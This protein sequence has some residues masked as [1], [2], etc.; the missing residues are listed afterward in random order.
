MVSSLGSDP[1]RNSYIVPNYVFDGFSSISCSEAQEN[2]RN[3][4][5]SLEPV[6]LSSSSANAT[7]AEDPEVF[8]EHRF[9]L[10]SS[11]LVDLKNGIYN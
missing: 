11:N 7:S 2:T 9:G 5:V 1:N 8:F 6:F 10:R 3:A 4:L